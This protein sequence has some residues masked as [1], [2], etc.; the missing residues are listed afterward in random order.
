MGVDQ[1]Q[2][3]RFLLQR[4]HERDQQAVLYDIGAIA[5]VKAM[6][7]IRCCSKSW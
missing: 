6:A 1:R 5:S 2:R 3:A 4:L 7:V